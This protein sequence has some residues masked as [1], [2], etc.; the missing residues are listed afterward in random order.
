MDDYAAMQRNKVLIHRILWMTLTDITMRERSQA[1]RLHIVSFHLCDILE[2][3]NY[4][5]REQ[6]S[7]EGWKEVVT[8]KRWHKGYFWGV[9]TVLYPD[10]HVYMNL[11]TC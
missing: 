7:G 1:Q 4:S 5:D 2:E 3:T 8:S 10:Y 11:Y 9:G 6:I